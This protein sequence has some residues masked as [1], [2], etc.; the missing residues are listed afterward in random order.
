VTFGTYSDPDG[1]AKPGKKVETHVVDIGLPR[2]YYPETL[3]LAIP[4]GIGELG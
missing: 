1:C 4:Y 3:L 2:S